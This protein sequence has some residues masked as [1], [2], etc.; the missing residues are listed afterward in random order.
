MRKM[1]RLTLVAGASAAVIGGTM[2]AAPSMAAPGGGEC[3]LKGTA[4]FHPGPGTNPSGAFAYDFGGA[5]TNCGDSTSG[6]AGFGKTTG[7]ITAGQ[8]LTIGGVTYQEPVPSGTGSCASGTTSGTS[9]VQWSDGTATVIKYTTTS[10]A[11]GVVLQGNVVPSI[12]L[13]NGTNS[14]TINST[15]FAGAGADGVLTFEVSDPTQCTASTGV[16]SAGI[17]GVTGLGSSS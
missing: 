15:R 6:P 7:T 12:T 5:L 10:A 4:N 9:I 8:T 1:V 11:A 17:D 14:T 3:T 16:V 2:L 13:T